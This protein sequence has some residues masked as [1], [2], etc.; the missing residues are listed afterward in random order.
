MECIDPAGQVFRGSDI[1]IPEEAGLFR[2]PECEKA[3]EKGRNTILCR[4]VLG[5]GTTLEVLCRRCKTLVKFK[6]GDQKTDIPPE[7]GR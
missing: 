7:A 6:A 5:K 3:R 2:C 4:G 1:A